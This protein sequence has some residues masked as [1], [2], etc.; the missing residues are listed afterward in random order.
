MQTMNSS[1]EQ[2]IAVVGVGY[3]GP[4]IVRNLVAQF[5]AHRIRIC[6]ANR[7]MLDRIVRIH[8]DLSTTTDFSRI[9]E[10]P[11]VKAVML[12]LPPQMHFPMGMQVLNAGKD[13]FVEKPAALELAH[14]KQLV[15]TANQAGKIFMVGHVYMYHGVIRAIDQFLR[16]G[17]LGK[18]RQILSW[19]TDMNLRHKNTNIL[20]SLLPHDL[21]I[22][23]LWLSKHP[24]SVFLSAEKMRHTEYEDKAHVQIVYPEGVTMNVYLS[25]V[26]RVK[27]RRICIIGSQGILVYDEIE[28]PDRFY[29]Y[30]QK[31]PKPWP[32]GSEDAFERFIEL[33]P[34]DQ[35]LPPTQPLREPLA[36][37]IAQY[38]K[39]ITTRKAPPTSGSEAIE[40]GKVMQAVIE[41]DS[42]PD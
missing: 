35:V 21:T 18:I 27:T 32:T 28:N 9:V 33:G 34:P 4:K 24:K 7:E 38:L 22:A 14:V 13:L 30:D 3:W 37:E 31:D 20:W 40:I 10:D 39:A 23:R 1:H 5:P 6:D 11:D 36:E 16:A 17:S 26:D 2:K 19:R 29:V 8:P 42:L 41:A 12:A 15:A 25:W